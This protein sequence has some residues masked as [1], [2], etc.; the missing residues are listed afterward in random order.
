MKNDS[1]DLKIKGSSNQNVSININKL[2]IR[3]IR[4]TKISIGRITFIPAIYAALSYII[5][6][7]LIYALNDPQY[8]TFGNRPPQQLFQNLNWFIKASLLG[9]GII[10]FLTYLFAY[11]FPRERAHSA[12][13]LV[14][15]LIHCIIG[16]GS[17]LYYNHS[18]FMMYAWPGMLSVAILWSAS[19]DLSYSPEKHWKWEALSF[20]LLFLAIIAFIPYAWGIS[21]KVFSH[22][23]FIRKNV[24]ITIQGLG[25]IF[26]I[27]VVVKR[28]SPKDKTHGIYSILT[29]M[30][31]TI[32]AVYEGYQHGRSVIEIIGAIEEL[33]RSIIIDIKGRTKKTIMY[34]DIE[35]SIEIIQKLGDIE[36]YRL[37]QL[38]W[39]ISCRELKRFGGSSPKDLGDGLLTTF[40]SALNAIKSAIAIQRA[41]IEFNKE[42]SIDQKINLRI[43]L[44]TGTI[45]LHQRWDPRGLESHLAQRV[46]AIARPGQILITQS[47]YDEAY[48]LDQKFK[49]TLLSETPL[50]GIQ[51]PIRIYE[52]QV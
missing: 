46:S 34:T 40:D 47:T 8:Y 32:K 23:T 31:L 13:M 29:L 12:G 48:N 19:I 24:I 17:S 51:S 10:F 3:E 25:L 6:C 33:L 1:E 35:H 30:G 50:K 14:L 45:F 43:G 5:I 16:L 52:V 28:L 18:H 26:F 20:I 4:P 44:N 36:A 37:F 49:A 42:R 22:D 39:E 27:Y 11:L 38:S 2:S 15:A 7:Y 9:G 41:H 21:H